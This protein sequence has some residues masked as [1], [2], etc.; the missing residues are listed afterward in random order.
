MRAVVIRSFGSPD[1][2][3][4]AE[5]PSPSPAPGQVLVQVEAAGVGGV[6]AVIRRGTLGAGYPLGMI[7]GGEVAGTVVDVGEGVDPEWIGRR[8]WAAT[9]TSGGYAEFARADLRDVTP[10]PDGLRVEDAVAL[11][12]A[13]TVAHFALEHAHHEPGESVLVRGASGSIGIAAVEHAARRGAWQVGVTTSSPERG[14]RLA[15]FGAT[16]VLDREGNVPIG[17]NP[18]YDVIIDIV[19]GERVPDFI[20]RLEPNGRL[21]LVGAVAGF[22]PPTFGQK[23][24]DGFRH[25]RSVAAF[26]LASV[27]V[28]TRNAGRAAQFEAAVRGELHPVV[29]AR[30]PLADAARAHAEMDAGEVFGRIVLIP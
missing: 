14:W 29:H 22:P 5:V 19:G 2:L 13:A 21:V 9:G 8:V 7:L 15:E 25:S 17:E 27:P 12:S 24:I 1:G 30:M 6:D 20:D 26:S 28:A 16:Q 10:L 23:L 18:R 4:V 11:G 3:E